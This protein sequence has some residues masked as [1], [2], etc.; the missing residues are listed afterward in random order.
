MLYHNPDMT[1]TTSL[2]QTQMKQSIKQHQIVHKLTGAFSLQSHLASYETLSSS[3]ANLTQH[4]NP[5]TVS[6]SAS[7]IIAD[8]QAGVQLLELEIVLQGQAQQ[9]GLLWAV[10]PVF[11]RLETRL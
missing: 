1:L 8:Q 5:H 9:L 4:T 7:V 3:T 6:Q 10:S 11:F 2:H